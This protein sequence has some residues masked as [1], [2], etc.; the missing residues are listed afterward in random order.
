MGKHL[1]GKLLR[2]IYSKTFTVVFLYTY[3]AHQ[4]GHN[5][6]K[7]F[8]VKQKTVKTT[9]VLPTDVFPYMIYYTEYIPLYVTDHDL[10]EA[11]CKGV[12]SDLNG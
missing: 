5:S 8:V 10:A 11:S 2:S 4:Q 6:Q 12:G 3:I 1:R 7:R 9:K